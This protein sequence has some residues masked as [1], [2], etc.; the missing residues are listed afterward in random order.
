MSATV[1]LRTKRKRLVGISLYRHPRMTKTKKAKL[2][3]KCL[4][5]FL[6]KDE[7]LTDEGEEGEQDEP[8]PLVGQEQGDEVIVNGVL[9]HGL[10]G[11]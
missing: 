7:Q 11:F 10:S 1:R 8:M 4:I 3:A 9:T 6:I 5:S 2:T